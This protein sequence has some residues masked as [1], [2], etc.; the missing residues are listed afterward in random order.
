MSADKLT[1]KRFFLVRRLSWPMALS[2]SLHASLIAGLLYASYHEIRPQPA[3]EAGQIQAIMV[4]PAMFAAVGQAAS[5]PQA[6]TASPAPQ[7]ASA[8]AAPS[9]TAPTAHKEKEPPPPEAPKPKPKPSERAQPRK[10]EVKPAPP[11]AK[12]PVPTPQATA[13]KAVSPMSQAAT[14][15]EKVP[16]AAPKATAGAQLGVASGHA[17]AASGGPP[18]ASGAPQAASRPEPVYPQRALALHIE[19]RVKLRFDVDSEGRV[20]NVT[21]LSADPPGVFER[22]VK[23]AARRWRYQPGRP[24][25]NVEVTVYFRIDGRTAVE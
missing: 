22:E 24:G 9:V 20:G 25:Q 17:P 23:R 8:A 21:I 4:N 13:A 19:G 5:A 11:K 7:E 12:P 6:A 14:S 3:E 1:L 2:V 10:R 15:P 18:A 16:G